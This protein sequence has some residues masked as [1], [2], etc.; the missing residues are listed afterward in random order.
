MYEYDKCM[1]SHV[2]RRVMSRQMNTAGLLSMRNR[3]VL[4]THILTKLSMT[5]IRRPPLLAGENVA[6]QVAEELEG[7]RTRMQDPMC[8]T[9]SSLSSYF[10]GPKP[11]R[12]EK[13]GE[14][15]SGDLKGLLSHAFQRW[16]LTFFGFI[17]AY[18]TLPFQPGL[19]PPGRLWGLHLTNPTLP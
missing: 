16:D 5:N 19:N 6:S 1:Y 11:H 7:S 3:E 10:P 4:I 18:P 15:G 8:F 17:V 14:K 2:S 9:T 13:K 12:H